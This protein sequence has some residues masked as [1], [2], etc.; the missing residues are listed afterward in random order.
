MTLSAFNEK[1]SHYT[2][3]SNYCPGGTCPYTCNDTENFHCYLVDNN[4]YILASNNPDGNGTGLFLGQQDGRLMRALLED[5]IFKMYQLTDYQSI[6]QTM[7]TPDQE[8]SSS[9]PMNP[10]RL[11]TRL[12]FWLISEVIIFLSEW[13]LFSSLSPYSVFGMPEPNG[14]DFPTGK[15]G[16]ECGLWIPERLARYIYCGFV[17]YEDTGFRPV[18]SI[19][20]TK[21][22]CEQTVSRFVLDKAAL[23]RRPARHKLPDCATQCATPHETVYEAR[24]LNETNL[25]FLVSDASCYCNSTHNDTEEMMD[26]ESPYT[27]KV[28]PKERTYKDDLQCQILLNYSNELKRVDNTRTQSTLCLDSSNETDKPC[29]QSNNAFSQRP[30]NER[31]ASVLLTVLTILTTHLVSS[32]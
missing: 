26:L 23:L 16:E 2:S 31:V 6:C 13:N 15:D 3:T 11:I 4:G 28:T 10:L 27:F 25:V 17:V 5:K 30:V 24:W 9:F 14:D 19:Y 21:R 20:T 32:C 8:S 1:F 29:G 12:F 18:M 7:L 22:S